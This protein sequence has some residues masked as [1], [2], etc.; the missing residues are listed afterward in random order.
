MSVGLPPIPSL[1]DADAQHDPGGRDLI[2]VLT[3]EHHA[4]DELRGELA[5]TGDPTRRRELAQVLVAMISRHLSAEEQ[6]LYPAVRAA[7]PDG[8]D[9]AERGLAT[10]RGVRRA[11]DELDRRPDTAGPG[12]ARAAGVV[13]HLAEEWDRHRRTVQETLLPQL[14][15]AATDEELIRL[16]N[17][18]EI[19]EEAGPTRPHPQAPLRPPWNRVVDPVL[20][21]VDKV[22]DLLGGRST[23]PEDL[24]GERP[25]GSDP[26]RD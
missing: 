8:T 20:G 11:L 9:L 12:R 2:T 18:A 7:L 16:G 3:S 15:A 19:A 5:G 25:G 24:P 4:I 1:G 14:R 21:T 17:R 23:Y 26:V 13:A 6:Y 22:R 10:D